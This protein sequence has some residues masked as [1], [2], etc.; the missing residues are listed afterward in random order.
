MS[1]VKSRVDADQAGPDVA[2]GVEAAPLPPIEVVTS[3]SPAIASNSP[4][5][6]VNRE[7]S[8]LAFNGRVLEEAQNLRHPLLE[9]LRFL[10]ISSSNL[11]EFYMVRVAGLWG[12][13]K[14]GVAKLSDDGLTPAKQLERIEECAGRLIADQQRVWI[15]LKSELAQRGISVINPGELD[16]ADRIWLDAYFHEQI[17]PVLT[18]LAIDPAHPFP[19][20]PNLGFTLALKL[21]RTRDGKLSMA[22]LP[23]PAQ[24][25]RFIRLPGKTKHARFLPLEEVIERY[26]DRLQALPAA[27]RPGAALSRPA[28]SRLHGQ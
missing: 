7:Q 13:V 27:R 19:F 20:I 4:E 2:A 25:Q 22:L 10:S 12:M 9:R 24:L 17:F 11:D 15:S 5:R 3:A 14:E 21:T 16:E 23:V 28:V 6:F 18:P 8:W 26:L 1:K